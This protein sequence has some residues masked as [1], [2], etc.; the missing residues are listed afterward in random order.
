MDPAALLNPRARHRGNYSPSS[1]LN[2]PS[3]Y[4]QLHYIVPN[5]SMSEGQALCALPPL[6]IQHIPPDL[7]ARAPDV[8]QLISSNEA[9]QQQTNL[10]TAPQI[11]QYDARALLNPKSASKRPATEQEPERGREDA[12]TTGQISLVERLHHVQGRTASPAKRAKTEEEHKKSAKPTSTFGSGSALDLNQNN[13]QLVPT[14]GASIDL[15]MSTFF[16]PISEQ[17]HTKDATGDDEAEFQVVKD[18][19]EQ[20]ICIGKVNKTYVQCHQVPYQD[21]KK[22]QGNHGSQGRIAIRFRRSSGN[23]NT[24]NIMVVDPTSREFGRVDL[25]TAKALAP[26]MDGSAASGLRWMAWTDARRKGKDEQGPGSPMSALI[27]MTLQLYCPRKHAHS[28]GKYLQMKQV[29]LGDPAYDLQRYDYFNPQTHNSFTVNEVI[30]P[31]PENPGYAPGAGGN[32]VLR[33]VDE[34]RSDVQTMFDT[35]VESDE[36]PSREPSP[37]IRTKLYKHQKQ[38]LYFLWDKEQDWQGEEGDNRKDSL[39]QPKYRSNG[40]KYY[41]HVITGEEATN[42]PPGCRGG[43][44]ADEMGLGK[45]L[46][47]LSLVADSESMATAHAFSQKAPP[48]RC[49][50]GMVQPTINSRATLLVCP[51]STMYNW[52]DQL[53]KHFPAGQNLKWMNYHGKQR[54]SISVRDLANNDIVIT[55]YQMIQADSNDRATPLP[56]VH[57]FRIVLD[58]AHTIRNATTKQSVAACSLPAQR[59]WAVTGT[60]VQNRLDVRRLKSPP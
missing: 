47:T 10:R 28:I 29:T 34:I 52:K 12:A 15:T 35:I 30:Q 45:T 18:N 4:C 55:T 2:Y 41:F 1:S 51:L 26:L 6:A 25:I 5:N 54:N 57:W 49:S 16:F 17:L 9:T 36:L 38:A 33:S 7:N 13:Q 24:L 40:R 22:Y 19:S 42:R 23:M 44:L 43:I 53:E 14:Q 27:G 8:P 37:M 20:I 56:H 3:P 60:P 11:Q 46:S 31:A 21:P 50:G 32:Y 58:E 48:P 59:R 39:W